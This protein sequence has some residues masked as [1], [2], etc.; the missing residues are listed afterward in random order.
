MSHF[1]CL[2]IGDDIDKQLAPF[3]EQPDENDEACKPLLEWRIY[4]KNG[5]YTAKTKEE[6]KKACIDAGD[7][8]DDGPY[9]KNPQAKWD[10]YV[11]G[12][13][14]TGFFKL[15]E[16]ATGKTGRP[17]IMTTPAEAG[18]AD[19][20]RKKDID[21]EGM[22][23]DAAAQAGEIYDLAMKIFGEAPVNESWEAMRERLTALGKPIQDIREEYHA[24]PRCEALKLHAKENKDSSFGMFGYSADNFL[25][26]REEF[27]KRAQI[28]TVSTYA[29][30]KDG[31][32]IEKGEMGWFGVS[33]DKITQDEWNDKFMKFLEELPDDTLLTVVDCHI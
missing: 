21:F 16:G 3:N 26:T 17:G 25:C 10:W 6:V 8:V 5:T 9:Y 2:V 18:K 20:V 32:W 14:W 13:R 31:E 24:Q 33:N 28:N 12:G 1:T 19:Q 15:K 11:V 30:L 23:A 22:F 4:G 29:I 27:I 7:T